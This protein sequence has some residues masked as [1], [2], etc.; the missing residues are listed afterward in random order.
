MPPVDQ[1]PL[2]FGQQYILDLSVNLHGNHRIS[3][4]NVSNTFEVPPGS[5]LDDVVATIDAARQR[6]ESLRT[7][8]SWQRSG[9]G[10]QTVVD[11]APL[12]VT[13]VEVAGGAAGALQEIQ[14][15]TAA[16][17]FD[18]TEQPPWRATV[19]TRDAAPVRLVVAAHHVLFDLQAMRSFAA[20]LWG[21][22]AERDALA[23]SP[24]AIARAQHSAEWSE[25]SDRA[26]AYWAAFSGLSGPGTTASLVPDDDPRPMPRRLRLVVPGGATMAQAAGR[27]AGVSPQA[28]LLSLALVAKWRTVG[29]RHAGLALMGSNR[30]NRTLAPALSSVVQT[31]PLAMEIDPAETF[32]QFAHRVQRDSFVAYGRASYDPRVVESTPHGPERR[33]DLLSRLRTSFNFMRFTTRRRGDDATG[34]PVLEWLPDY[35]P[36]HNFAMSFSLVG[37]QLTCDL[38]F[39]EQVLTSAA[40]ERLARSL[41]AALRALGAGAGPLVNDVLG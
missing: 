30:G 12:P 20:C 40:A 11:D 6:Y 32:G 24:L 29:G 9:P 1:A 15:A 23:V 13:V 35:V 36:T 8:Y 17:Q 31:I 7:I 16:G 37:A 22:P 33:I 26:D 3:G 4:L 10:T 25:L 5:T 27:T 28:V 41:D 21:T 34:E 14:Q 19:V 2:T 18:V 38:R 39:D